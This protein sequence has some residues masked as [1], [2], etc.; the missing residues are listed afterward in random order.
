M[1]VLIKN[2]FIIQNSWENI[3][4]E[5][6]LLRTKKVIIENIDNWGSHENDLLCNMFVSGLPMICL[7]ATFVP[8]FSFFTLC[9]CVCA[10]L[11]CSVVFSPHHQL[12]SLDIKLH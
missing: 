4:D 10:M 5:N 8:F 7:F 3:L 1:K 11:L 6:I 12:L 2:I 9:S